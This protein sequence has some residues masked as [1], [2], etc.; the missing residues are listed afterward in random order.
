MNFMFSSA[1]FLFSLSRRAVHH[2][3]SAVD[4]PLNMSTVSLM[5][6]F[7]QTLVFVFV[8]EVSST[9]PV[10]K[11]TVDGNVFISGDH[12]E[13][14]LSSSQETKKALA[15]IQSELFSLH[16]KDKKFAQRILSLEKHTGRKLDLMNN[17]NAAL[18]A[19]VQ[20]MSQ[21]LTTLE[22]QGTHRELF[23]K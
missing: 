11:T 18:S 16:E 9:T 6:R 10:N 13:V 21:R 20:A 19:Q 3:V 14:V 8:C 15:K 7:Y 22:K 2:S 12:N 4:F 5:R 17:S 1:V 23:C